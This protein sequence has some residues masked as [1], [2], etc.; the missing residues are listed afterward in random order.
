MTEVDKTVADETYHYFS[1]KWCTGF[2]N[3]ILGIKLLKCI[4]TGKRQEANFYTSSS[5]ILKLAKSVTFI[6][7][8]L[9]YFPFCLQI[10]FW[11]SSPPITAG[12]L[13]NWIVDVHV[14]VAG[15]VFSQILL[16]LCHFDPAYLLRLFPSLQWGCYS[17][18]HLHLITTV[19]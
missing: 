19:I 5:I 14:N 10:H 18:S 11:G 7:A 17:Y 1:C 3:P 6:V 13:Y 16:F 4:L 2:Q 9:H 12:L 8:F 15:C